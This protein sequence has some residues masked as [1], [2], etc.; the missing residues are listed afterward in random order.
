MTITKFHSPR[1]IFRDPFFASARQLFHEF[2]SSDLHSFSPFSDLIESPEKF[3]IQL[4]LP[5]FKKEDVAIDLKNDILTVSGERKWVKEESKQYH[6]IQTTY[7]KFSK[8]FTLNQRIDKSG[9]TAEFQDGL[10]LISLPKKEKEAI[11]SSSIEI[12]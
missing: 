6:S 4:A 11:V 5:G 10:L 1:S 12:K 2:D 7:G 9:I 8:S 3:E